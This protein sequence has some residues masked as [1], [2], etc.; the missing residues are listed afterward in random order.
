MPLKIYKRGAIWHYRG[1]V[2]GRLLRGSTRTASKEIA[3]RICAEQEARHWKGH[4]DGP[5]SVL[6]FA[7]AAMLYRAAGKSD[8]FLRP[9]EDYWKDTPVKAINA[10]AIRQSA[11]ELYPTAGPATRNRQGIVPA[12]AI[13][14][15]SADQELCPH[16][17]VKRFHVV[18]KAKVP[19]TWEWVQAFMAHAG[20]PGLAA[21]CCF[22]YLTG[23]R[24][25]RTL[26][27]TW[28][29]VDFKAGTVRIG[30]TKGSDE[31]LAHMPPEL[32]AALAN[33]P[34]ERTGRVFVF[35]SRGNAKTQWAGACRRAGIK[36]LS[37]HRCRHGF[38]SVLLDRGVSPI[39]VADRG[40]WKDPRHV[41]QTYGHDIAPR[42]VTDVLTDT[43]ATQTERKRNAVN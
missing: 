41:F 2:A 37:Y 35:K 1:T 17:R 39:T 31:R 3:Q 5:A 19:V 8:R 28:D 33:I 42:D 25:T 22:M 29:D 6:T 15:H 24:I 43:P 38:A 40:G 4:L 16:I 21:L 27:V 11:I 13:I 9:V 7:Q 18:K 30:G 23:E 34:G 14:N 36:F 10:G 26:A 20:T 32:I 12:Q